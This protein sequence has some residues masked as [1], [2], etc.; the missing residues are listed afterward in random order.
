MS[1][2]KLHA[3]MTKI[4][5]ALFTAVSSLSLS[6][7]QDEDYGFTTQDVRDGVYKRNFEKTYGN[8]SE[9]PTWDFSSYNL[10]KMGLTGGPSI[11][12]SV[13]GLQTRATSGLVQK[14][15]EDTY[16]YWY[17]VEP[18][19]IT[20]LNKNLKEK[21]DNTK[22]TSPFEW[23]PDAGSGPKG[24]FY[25]IPIYQGQTGMV[26]NLELV[27]IIS[28]TGRINTS[29]IIWT[30]SEN[31]QYTQ[32]YSK[33]EEFFYESGK[34]SPYSSQNN[35]SRLNFASAL[36]GMTNSTSEVKIAFSVSTD[37]TGAFYVGNDKLTYSNAQSFFEANGKTSEGDFSF[38][39]GKNVAI[40]G[41]QALTNE[42]NGNVINLSSLSSEQLKNLNFRITNDISESQRFQHWSRDYI[43]VFVH[44]NGGTAK[45][46]KLADFDTNGQ[47]S[48]L[49]HNTVNKYQV[50][51]RPI[52]I[53][54]NCIEGSSFAFN[55]KTIKRTDGDSPYSE[56][57]DDHRSD[58]NFMS[59]ITHF[60]EAVISN[61]GDFKAEMKTKF[62]IDLADNFEYKVIGCEDA[63]YS[64][65]ESDQDYNDVVFLL[66]GDKLPNQ[67]I[68][69]RYMIEDLGSTYDFD[70]NDI[71]V[72]VTE[73]VTSESDGSK[74][75]EQTAE[76]KHLCG[77]IP[78]RV[79]IGNKYFGGTDASGNPKIMRGHINYTPTADDYKLTESCTQSATEVNAGTRPSIR[80]TFW[81]PEA[82]NITVEVWPNYASTSEGI[83][84]DGVVSDVANNIK[85]DK[86]NVQVRQIVEFPKT[87]KVPYIIA[88]DQNVMWMDECTNIPNNWVKT[89]PRPDKY[90]N[91]AFPIAPDTN[92]A[93]NAGS[94]TGNIN[95][96]TGNPIIN[97][98][99][100]T[101]GSITLYDTSTA[102]SSNNSITIDKK[103]LG[104]VYVGDVI[105]VKVDGIVYDKSRLSFMQGS[106]T[107]KGI[108]DIGTNGNVIVSGDYEVKV[109][110]NMMNSLKNNGLVING[111]NVTVSS[112][113]VRSGDNTATYIS[114]R[115]DDA[116]RGSWVISETK[117][118]D[119]YSDNTQIAKADLQKLYVGD[120]IVVKLSGLR[121]DSRI[122]FKKT[123][124]NWSG[125]TY[126]EYNMTGGTATETGGNIIPTGDIT[127][128]VTESNIASL[129][130][131]SGNL[132]INGY[133]VTI[134]SVSV[135]TA[136]GN[137]ARPV[138]NPTKISGGTAISDIQ[139]KVI[140]YYNGNVDIAGNNFTS[141]EEG[142][143]IVIHLDNIR[144]NSALGIRKYNSNTS[145]SWFGNDP[146][147]SNIYSLNGDYALTVTSE[148]IEDIKNGIRI[149]GAYI[150]I[151]GVSIKKATYHVTVTALP[152]GYG[153]V[154]IE[155]GS[156]GSTAE[157]DFEKGTNLTLTAQA[158][159]GYSFIKW[160]SNQLTA[161]RTLQ[162]S[163]NHNPAAIFGQNI[164]SGA[165]GLKNNYDFAA[166][167]SQTG[168][169]GGDNPQT[170]E[171][172]SAV[173]K[174]TSDNSTLVFFIR[175]E[176]SDMSEFNKA[177][178]SFY[179]NNGTT[180]I[181]P[182]NTKKLGNMLLVK[183]NESDLNEG[184][185]MKVAGMTND[186]QISV[187]TVCVGPTAYLW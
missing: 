99:Q 119:D 167:G 35:Y 186:A 106:D 98:I 53:D 187:T 48:Y 28:T 130:D 170:I 55:L 133:K 78:F 62:G 20:W 177:T 184:F 66:V 129:R 77:T 10:K 83:Y 110:E 124:D 80:S 41:N 82:N 144:T 128:E 121:S 18:A 157:G 58:Q 79:K 159:N 137:N 63:G 87:G 4:T 111:Q 141:I 59:L 150:N 76:I 149:T 143:Q 109:T 155:S 93:L 56:I 27:D 39:T 107:S 140:A 75:Y 68:K 163:S 156:L 126:S 95:Q 158:N 30:K 44:Y 17:T 14:Y 151:T 40:D 22:Y 113:T 54:M 91:E 8:I 69:K 116:N 51:T 136:S 57:G 175:D 70:F 26:W 24:V 74:K 72:D 50:Q 13:S 46:I 36:S 172:S 2:T 173:S 183:F 103:T 60:D 147:N 85:D 145:V 185:Y 125:L 34:D 164:F 101:V 89:S 3:S 23:V 178:F 31:I 120:K 42:T 182:L 29:S 104:A 19:T 174:I 102:L 6:S 43:R 139:K 138:A 166:F 152:N 112:V 123:W 160:S 37:I 92:D 25:V 45:P 132:A 9:V 135:Q 16:P 165:W 38:T 86:N 169:T 146:S 73:I 115:T 81:D 7:C 162:V 154:Q 65:K 148:N 61:K 1:I 12:S 64:G 52:K 168:K 108:S 105:V 176:S 118:L 97:P 11:S 84:W 171:Y 131:A 90:P 122:G 142:D 117:I 114:N 179:K 47:N 32:D 71:V 161:S 15:P 180:Q 21:V 96:T 153:Q 33:W 88:T 94:A 134:E 5:L 100:S 67:V 49:K 127:L 181:T